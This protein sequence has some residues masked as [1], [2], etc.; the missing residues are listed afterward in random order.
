M[1]TCQT[2]IV[3]SCGLAGASDDKLK[4]GDIV[5]ANKVI[6]HD[7]VAYVG[8]EIKQRKLRMYKNEKWKKVDWMNCNK[9]FI[10]WCKKAFSSIENG[11]MPYFIGTI[12]TGDQLILSKKHRNRISKDYNALAID[13]ES[14]SI[15]HVCDMFNVGFGSL[16]VISDTDEIEVGG[17]ITPSLIKHR[18]QDV[19]KC[20]ALCAI[21]IKKVL[22]DISW[23]K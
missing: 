23:E 3:I 13:M 12:V 7:V 8:D 5:V 10:E 21:A 11:K 6:Q 9:I 14:A 18:R 17:D 19:K 1:G 20:S 16:R 4:F 2:D 22:K 15:A